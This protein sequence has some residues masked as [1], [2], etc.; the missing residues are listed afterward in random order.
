MWMLTHKL[1]IPKLPPNCFL[2]CY[3]IW[4]RKRMFRTKVQLKTFKANSNKVIPTQPPTLSTNSWK[5][6]TFRRR[7]NSALPKTL[8][9]AIFHKIWSKQVNLGAE[10]TLISMISKI[11]MFWG[12]VTESV[13]RVKRLISNLKWY[14][15]ILKRILHWVRDHLRITR[16]RS[17]RIMEVHSIKSKIQTAWRRLKA[18]LIFIKRPISKNH[19]KR[20]S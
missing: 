3:K 15:E 10:H 19:Q 8:V 16:H 9:S 12:F 11:R 20:N 14:L 1:E 4:M 5:T 6:S 2:I 18:F 17:I 13:H 7:Y